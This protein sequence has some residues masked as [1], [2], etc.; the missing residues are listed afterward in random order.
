MNA[1][2]ICME[3]LR[4]GRQLA[5]A[6]ADHEGIGRRLIAARQA[7]G[8][9]AVELAEAAGVAQNALSNW[10][11]GSRRPSIDQLAYLLPI[12]KV[13]SDWIYF[14]N[15]TG[16]DWRVKE[17]IQRELEA[18]PAKTDGRRRRSAAA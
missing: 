2:V 5:Q 9:Q 14:G 4:A 8:L 16:L 13:S 11:N 6:A 12:L 3:K 1:I 18:L 15:D 7:A 10:E 17:A